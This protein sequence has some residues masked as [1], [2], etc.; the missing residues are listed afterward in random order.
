MSARSDMKV[1]L[2]QHMGSDEMVARAARVSTGN[3]KLDL[4]KISGLIGYLVREQHTSPL[5]HCVVTVRAEVPIFVAREWM[6]HRTQSYSELSLRF[7][8]AQPEFYLPE[9]SRPLVNEGTG[10]HPNLVRLPDDEQQALAKKASVLHEYAY[11]QAWG[12]YEGMIAAGVANEVARNVLPVSIYTS[13]Y[14]T[15]N[16]NNWFK[17]LTLRNGEKGAPQWE[18]VQAALQVEALISDLFPITYTAWKESV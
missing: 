3:D 4:K 15:A 18:I 11:M 9:A 6:R 2:V 7:A 12:A 8:E 16:L 13:F 5:E 1:E 14:A 10:A 17:F